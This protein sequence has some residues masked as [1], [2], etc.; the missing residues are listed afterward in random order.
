[1]KLLKH[2]LPIEVQ[3]DNYIDNLVA[4]GLDVIYAIDKICCQ[5]LH[6]SSVQNL[7]ETVPIVTFDYPMASSLSEFF[8][9]CHYKGHEWW[10]NTN[11]NNQNNQN[12]NRIDDS[13]QNKIGER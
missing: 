3:V 4:S 2:C 12:Q 1:K 9:W 13:N 8:I 10:N 7:R 6:L 5:D 11:Q